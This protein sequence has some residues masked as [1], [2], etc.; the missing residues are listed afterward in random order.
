MPTLTLG[1]P[2]GATT[3]VLLGAFMINGI[4]PGP[5]L[6]EEQPT[7]VWGL[8]ASFFIGNVILLVLNLPLAP[9]FAQILRVPYGYMYPLILLTSFVGAYSIT[10]SMFSVWVVLVFGIIGYFMKR[11]DLPDGAARPRPGARPAV[12][13]G[14]GA[15]LGASATATWPSSSPGRSSWWSRL[16]ASCSWPR[17]AI[18]ARLLRGRR[19]AS[20]P[21]SPTTPTTPGGTPDMRCTR[22][23]RRAGRSAS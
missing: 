16:V 11:L 18:F 4:Q 20:R 9:V 1:I 23:A 3:A 19:A 2:G 14:A 7:L 21:G 10:N 17:P 8:I 22:A 6:F 15:D 12:R 5:L 13:E